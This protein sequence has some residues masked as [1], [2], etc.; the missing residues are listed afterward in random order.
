MIQT[1]SLNGSSPGISGINYDVGVDSCTDVM[2]GLMPVTGSDVSITDSKIRSIGLWFLGHDTISVNGL[3]DNSTYADFEAS[4]SDRLLHLKNCTVQTWSL[5]PM[6]TVDL[7]VT[8]CILGEIGSEVKCTVFVTNTF[9]DGSGG[10][11]WST[12]N[13]FMVAQNCVGVNAVR[14]AR[15]SVF[16]YAYST[17]MQ[18]EASAMDNSILMLVQ[19]LLPEEPRLYQGSCIWNAFIGAPSSVLTDTVSPVYGFAWIDKTATSQLMDFGWYRLFCQ[20]SGDTAWIPV[21][22]KVYNERRDEVLGNWDTHGL[23]PGLYY[24]KLQLSDDGADSIRIEAVKGINVLPGIFGIEDVDEHPN[25]I[26]AE[27]VMTKD[28]IV[29]FTL[30]RSSSVAVSLIDCNGQLIDRREDRFPEGKQSLK[31]GNGTLSSGMYILDLAVNGKHYSR[32]FLTH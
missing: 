26:I 10:Y 28:A 3:V 31:L 29:S 9:V 14:S 21:T 4:L 5:Y 19:S 20:K 25:L 2:W 27:D 16:I 8:G 22:D 24:L 15:N 11:W 23:D 30:T 7:N 32:K 17:L 6:D 1:F 13:T 18:G 12:D